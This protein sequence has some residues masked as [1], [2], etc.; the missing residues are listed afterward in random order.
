MDLDPQD[1]RASSILGQLLRLSKRREVTIDLRKGSP[2]IESPHRSDA[3]SCK[4]DRS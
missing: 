3:V 2:W 4:E 1:S